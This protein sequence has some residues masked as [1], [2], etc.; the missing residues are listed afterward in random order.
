[1]IEI[2]S[3]CTAA[4]RKAA[5]YSKHFIA[6]DAEK[7]NRAASGLDAKAEADAKARAEAKA[8]DDQLADE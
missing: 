6:G 1:M 3:D 8:V 5:T 4:F 7:A 2:L